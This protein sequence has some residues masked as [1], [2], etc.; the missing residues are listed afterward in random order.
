MVLCLT[1]LVVGYVVDGVLGAIVF[2]VPG[3]AGCA[4]GLWL[5]ERYL[6]Y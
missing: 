6:S 1:M 5:S 4:F 3:A 2:L